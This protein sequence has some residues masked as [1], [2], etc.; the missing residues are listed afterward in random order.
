M[1]EQSP[2]VADLIA[3][4]NAT[5]IVLS[6][7]LARLRYQNIMTADDI[8]EITQRCTDRAAQLDENTESATFADIKSIL[9]DAAAQA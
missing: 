2:D 4:L 7:I 6:A 9:S 8:D 3:K 1:T 5:E